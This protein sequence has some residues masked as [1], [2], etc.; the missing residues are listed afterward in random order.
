MTHAIL[1]ILTERGI[2]TEVAEDAARACQ[3]GKILLPK[4]ECTSFITACDQDE[5]TGIWK[6]TQQK[7]QE[8]Q[9]GGLRVTSPDTGQELKTGIPSTQTSVS[10]VPLTTGIPTGQQYPYQA[11]TGNIQRGYYNLSVHAPCN[12]DGMNTRPQT[13]ENVAGS[14]R[15]QVQIFKVLQENIIGKNGATIQRIREETGTLIEFPKENSKSD[16]I[17]ITGLKENVEAAKSKIEAIQEELKVSIYTA[18]IRA[19]PEYHKLLKKRGGYNIKNVSEKTGVCAM[20]PNSQA[21]DRDLI[22]I[23]GD[24][25]AVE[26]AKEELIKTLE[27]IVEDEVNVDPKHQHYFEGKKNKVL[28]QIK[29]EYDLVSVRYQNSQVMNGC[30]VLQGERDCVEGAKK[31]ILEIVADIPPGQQQSY[32]PNPM[33]M[34]YSRYKPPPSQQ[35]SYEPNPMNMEYGRYKPVMQ[36]PMYPLGMNM[37]PPVSQNPPG[38]QH[39]YEQNP[40]NKKYGGHKPVIQPL[41]HPLPPRTQNPPGQQHSYKPNKTNM[42]YGRYKPVMQPPMYPLE[43]NMRPPGS[44]NPPGQQHSYEPNQTNMEYVRYK[45]VMQPPMY[46]LGMNMRPPGSQNPP[47]QQHS[48]EPNPMNMEYGGHKPVMQPP[49]HPLGMNMRQPTNENVAGNYRTQVQIF[50]VLQENIIGKN[51]ATIQRIR[52]ETGTL[53]EFPSENSKS[54]VII[55][56]GLKDNVEAAKSKIEAIQ[57]ELKVSKYTAEIRAKPEY[58]KLLRKRGGYNIKNVSEKTGVCAMFPNSQATDRDLISIIG[59]KDAVEKA[60]EELIKTLDEVNVVPKHQY[61]FE[62]KKNKVLR[63]LKDEYD[64]VSVIYQNSQV[65][66]GCVVLQGERDCVEGAKK[67]ILEIVADMVDGTR[68][69][70]IESSDR[71]E[72]KHGY[73]N[74]TFFI[75][76]L[77]L[78]AHL[79]LI[80]LYPMQDQIALPMYDV[81]RRRPSS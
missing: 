22:S 32:E 2:V 29:D 5:I 77:T 46:P 60:K 16:V 42:K 69:T 15:T 80:P 47:G 28:R 30:V 59:D 50:K 11:N 37:R 45:P 74:H 67:K 55:I 40:K 24:K 81:H 70:L 9:G 49:M 56:T 76:S 31:K 6:E 39:S 26:K 36:P 64:L 73:D 51:G 13:Q 71:P 41:K 79:P 72:R 12:P 8:S 23:I 34:E 63:Q 38:Q 53:I 20:F 7:D 33:N 19:K 57:E 21:T 10:T 66:N 61:Y 52:E 18:E 48:Y 27:N 54:D 62:G 35:H 75:V 43:M 65:M 25:D 14:Y 58:H 1:H 3:V 17:I 68:R 78:W 4:E 44:Q